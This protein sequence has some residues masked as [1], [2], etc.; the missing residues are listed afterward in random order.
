MGWI[1][2]YCYFKKSKQLRISHRRFRLYT[3][4]KKQHRFALSRLLASIGW[5]PPAFISLRQ[6]P[7]T[8]N[9]CYASEWCRVKSLDVSLSFCPFVSFLSKIVRRKS[10][11]TEIF[12]EGN[13][14][15]AGSKC[16]RLCFRWVLS[17]FFRRVLFYA[18]HLCFPRDKRLNVSTKNQI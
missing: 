18:Y 6:F 5:D 14:W 13:I 12:R 3:V 4:H 7:P 16:W 8:S 17:P 10:G 15:S 9:M 1:Y 2:C 11:S